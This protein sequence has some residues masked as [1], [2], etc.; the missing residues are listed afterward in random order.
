MA[1]LLKER[2]KAEKLLE[3]AEREALRRAARLMAS[4]IWGHE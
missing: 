1:G 3:K 4:L 2:E